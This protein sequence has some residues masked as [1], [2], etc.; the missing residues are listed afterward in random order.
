M[1]T[2]LPV[3]EM[4]KEELVGVADDLKEENKI[5]REEIRVLRELVDSDNGTGRELGYDLVDQLVYKLPEG[6]YDDWK[7]TFC[8]DD[9]IFKMFS[10]SYNYRKIRN[11]CAVEITQKK[12]PF[13]YEGMDPDK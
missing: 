13:Q 7:E 5:L 11:S 10:F 9:E 4:T 8:C 6:L 2:G 1:V 3:A 12:W